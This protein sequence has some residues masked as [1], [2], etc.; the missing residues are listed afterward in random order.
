MTVDDML[1]WLYDQYKL[2]VGTRTIRRAFERRKTSH[3]KFRNDV[4]NELQTSNDNQSPPSASEG[5]MEH[6]VHLP[7]DVGLYQSP[8][9]P[10]A[11][12]ADAGGSSDISPE[13]ARAL[14]G[15]AQGGSE[16]IHPD[17]AGDEQELSEDEETLQ[18][19]LQQIAL[20]KR[21]VEL[22]LKMRRLQKGKHGSSTSRHSTGQ[23]SSFFSDT[24]DAAG[25]S[26]AAASGS[27]SALP[28]PKTRDSR[29]KNKIEEAKRRTEERQEKMLKDL[30][31]R[32]RRREHLTAEWVQVSHPSVHSCHQVRH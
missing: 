2:V 12:T 16:H 31:R 20:Q 28:K 6:M 23:S 3:K 8:Y 32:S 18:L 11:P 26:D 13:L 1:W 25:D 21:E 19:Q 15:L 10:I 27:T 7:S 4:R 29:S 17:L 14:S 5:D 22:K 9:P 30:E 24:N